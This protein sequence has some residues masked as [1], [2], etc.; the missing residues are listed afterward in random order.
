MPAVGEQGY[1][2]ATTPRYITTQETW[3]MALSN[4]ERQKRWRDKRNEALEV[5]RGTP[6][7]IAH[8]LVGELGVEQGRKVA[9]AMR[10]RLR[11]INPDCPTCKGVGFFTGVLTTECGIPIFK[12]NVQS[13]L[14][15]P[16]YRSIHAAAAAT[17]SQT[18]ADA[19]CR[20]A[21]PPV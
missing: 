14:P 15:C 11:H 4:A 13:R 12:G 5:L 8:K 6:T 16:C 3:H 2:A 21:S 7:E 20:A 17:D 18:A 9:E 19:R 10:K 1:A